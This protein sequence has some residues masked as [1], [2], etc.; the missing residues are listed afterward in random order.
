[1]ERTRPFVSFGT[2][3]PRAVTLL[4]GIVTLCLALLA[5]LPSIWPDAL[6]FLHPLEV[7]T[8][9]EN[10]LPQDEAVRVFHNRMKRDLSIRDMVVV[11]ITLK[12]SFRWLHH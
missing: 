10:M 5:G 8:D 9:P 7:D 12:R 1:M 6:P 11:G 3:H 4:T 2:G